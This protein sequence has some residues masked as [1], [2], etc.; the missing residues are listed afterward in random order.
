[1][2]AVLALCMVA[3]IVAL[4]NAE[5][6][7]PVKKIAG[8]PVAPGA[9]AKRA[10]VVRP[11]VRP[12]ARPAGVRPAIIPR[13]PSS[14]ATSGVPTAPAF[15]PA[16]MQTQANYPDLR[17]DIFEMPPGSSIDGV[18]WAPFPNNN[19]DFKQ[20]QGFSF[21]NLIYCETAVQINA[22]MSRLVE[23]LRGKWTWWEGGKQTDL[24]VN[25][26]G[27]IDYWL[28][29]STVIVKVHE[30]MAVPVAL[31]DGPYKGG[32]VIRIQFLNSP[33]SFAVG[34]GYFLLRPTPG[35]FGLQT[36]LV[37]RFAGVKSLTL[38]TEFFTR[39]HLQAEGGNLF[40]FGK[41]TGLFHL[42]SIAEGLEPLP[43]DYHFFSSFL[44]LTDAQHT[45]A[46][47]AVEEA[48]DDA[49]DEVEEDSDE[50]NEEEEE[51]SEEE[52]DDEAEIDEEADEESEEGSE[53]ID[54]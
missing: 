10:P 17:A 50:L 12:A 30:V 28:Y 44:Q 37:G 29:P 25:S 39:A 14:K 23:L 48:A 22:P 21:D 31:T 40:G 34:L 33:G 54:F 16:G 5:G 3:T 26:D 49:A 11:A 53:E 41:K 6:V 1:M 36:D 27:T 24:K 35:T 18:R 42:K 2:K 46:N 19:A 20:R 8:G 9:S 32:I 52:A 13:G 15:P 43:T 51:E 45:E 47:E 38:G 4:S 7:L